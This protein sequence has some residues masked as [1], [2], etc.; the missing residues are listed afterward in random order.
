MELTTRADHRCV[1]AFLE[2][3][4]R[5]LGDSDVEELGVV[6]GLSED[7]SMRKRDR[8]VFTLV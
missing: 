2:L 3:H 1:G 6:S 5:S 7:I 4:L 8:S